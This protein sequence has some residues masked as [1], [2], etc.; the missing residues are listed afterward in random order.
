MNY[1]ENIPELTEDYGFCKVLTI[2][3]EMI[4]LK[5]IMT[6]CFVN[7]R[8]DIQSELKEIDYDVMKYM[9]FMTNKIRK[10]FKMSREY[11]QPVNDIIQCSLRHKLFDFL[12]LYD[13]LRKAVVLDFDGVVTSK[14]FK[15]FYE[16]LVAENK[17]VF[18]CSANPSVNFEWFEKRGYPKPRKIFA[19][20]GKKKK[21][22][23]LVEIARKFNVFYI[24]NEKMYLTTAYLF[25]INCYHYDGTRIKYFSR[26]VS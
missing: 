13:G 23:Q 9:F 11:R 2:R 7:G 8:I 19:C 1:L 17:N 22:R 3:R 12:K 15:P 6:D 26:Q 25:G 20:K 5:H 10:L 14:K 16:R 24:D 18:I 4:H 21:L